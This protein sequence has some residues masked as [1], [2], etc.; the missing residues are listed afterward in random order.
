MIKFSVCVEMIFRDLPFVERVRKVAEAGAEGVEFWRWDNKEDLDGIRKVADECGVKIVAHTGSPSNNL[1]NPDNKKDYIEGL[2]KGIEVA[3]KL[4]CS[5]LLQTTGNELKDVPRAEQHRSIV[6]HLKEAAP[7]V[8]DAGVV[9]VLEPLNTLVDHKGYYLDSTAEAVEI[10]QEV[11]SP[12]V[13]LLYDIYHMQIME[14]N[15]IQTIE[16][17]ISLIGH[18]H[19]A[20]VPGRHEPGTGELNYGS[21][22]RKIDEL[23]Y[24]GFVGMEFKPLGDHL[25]AVKSVMAM[26]R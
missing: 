4:G 11:N 23:G 15:I 5:T 12:N 14:G 7:I 9:L 21:I 19:I 18:F 3:K 25:E 1:V 24:D 6:E 22:F 17:N 16:K 13:K 2:R 20:D 8:E 26:A 10:L